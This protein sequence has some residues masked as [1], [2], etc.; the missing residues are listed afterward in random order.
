VDFDGIF[1]ILR[2]DRFASFISVEDGSGEGDEGLR[3][4]I[5]FLRGLIRRYWPAVAEQPGLQEAAG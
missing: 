3:R 1:A 2:E 4:G 5:A